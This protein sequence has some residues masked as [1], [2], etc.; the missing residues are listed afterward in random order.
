MGIVDNVKE[1]A[2]LVKKIGDVE[3]YRRIVELEGDVIELTRQIRVLEQQNEELRS[4]LELSAKLTFREPFYYA[5]NDPVP[6]CPRCFEVDR[7]AVHLNH[8]F[9]NRQRTRYDCKQCKQMFLIE[10]TQGQRP[11]IPFSGGAGG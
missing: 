1:L 3:L 8:E 7:R 2:D 9:T 6:H 5:P 4:K 10:H 11:R